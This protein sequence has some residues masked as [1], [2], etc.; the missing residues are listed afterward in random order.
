[1]LFT[2]DSQSFTIVGIDERLSG[3]K[4]VSCAHCNKKL[5]KHPFLVTD[6]N[7]NE[8]VVGSDCI[9]DHAALFI[10]NAAQARADATPPRSPLLTSLTAQDVLDSALRCETHRLE[11]FIKREISLNKKTLNK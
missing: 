4:N 11:L 8:H 2:T 3:Q 9:L 6:C 7:G 5:P 10:R 1:M